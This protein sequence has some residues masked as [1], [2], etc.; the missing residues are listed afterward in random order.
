MEG[1]ALKRRIIP[2]SILGV[3]VL[4]FLLRVIDLGHLPGLNG[5]EAWYGVQIQRLQASLPVVFRAPSGR[6]STNI[7][8]AALLA[9][10]QLVTGPA[11]WV[12]RVPAV[13]AGVLTV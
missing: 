11:I 9:P 3:L 6:L 5:D 12:L 7:F 1:A 4:A 2:A 10:L 8:L 13:I